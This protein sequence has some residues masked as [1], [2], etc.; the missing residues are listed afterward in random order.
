VRQKNYKININGNNFDTKDGTPERDFIHIKDLCEIHKKTYK[1]LAKNKRLIL[2][3][4]SGL[5]YSVLEIVKAIEKKI[6]KVYFDRGLYKYH[7]RIKTF[8]D[9]LR[10]KG[11]EF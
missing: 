9:I 4:G 8:A 2:N 11:M 6:M 3:C 10:K 1:Y 5:R 7:G